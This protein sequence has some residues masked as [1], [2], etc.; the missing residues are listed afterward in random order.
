MPELLQCDCSPKLVSF[1]SSAASMEN[2]SAKTLYNDEINIFYPIWLNVFR[3]M[4]GCGR[5]DG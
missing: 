5:K 2:I 3:A 4:V 1:L